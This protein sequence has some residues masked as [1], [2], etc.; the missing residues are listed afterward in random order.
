[1]SFIEFNKFLNKVYKRYVPN[2]ILR[3][4]QIL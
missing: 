4:V 2:F 3:D 1:M